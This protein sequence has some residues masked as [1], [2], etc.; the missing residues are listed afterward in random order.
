MTKNNILKDALVFALKIMLVIVLVILAFVIG[1]MVGY[2]VVG[3]GEPTGVFSTELWE[4]I[5]SFFKA[6]AGQ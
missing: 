2:G 5:F 3:D 1:G 6:P 4:G